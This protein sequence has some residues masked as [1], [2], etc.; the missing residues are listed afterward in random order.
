MYLLQSTT[1]SQSLVNWLQKMRPFAR[2]ATKQQPA[3]QG[4]TY[5][6]NNRVPKKTKQKQKKLPSPIEQTPSA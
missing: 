4:C 2:K 6:S 1:H 3:I 5:L